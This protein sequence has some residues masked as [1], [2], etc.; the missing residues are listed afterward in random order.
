M[1]SCIHT[2]SLFVVIGIC[3]RIV[4][5]DDTLF[6]FSI[7]D[8]NGHPQSLDIYKGMVSFTSNVIYIETHLILIDHHYCTTTVQIKLMLQNYICVK[9]SSLLVI[10]LNLFKFI[11][12]L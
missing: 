12:V 7:K 6:Q 8:P 4:H 2:F 3:G 10:I 5:A 1:M 11:E 9:L